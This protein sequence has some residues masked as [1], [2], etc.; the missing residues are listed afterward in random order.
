MTPIGMKFFVSSG[1]RVSVIA[2]MSTSGV[3]D[4]YLVDGAVNGDILLKYVQSSLHG[5]NFET[6]DGVNDK[7]TQ[8]IY[9]RPGIKCKNGC[10]DIALQIINRFYLIE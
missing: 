6:F 4:Y 5:A 3:E 9:N 7:S 10:L 8:G 1:K 2:T